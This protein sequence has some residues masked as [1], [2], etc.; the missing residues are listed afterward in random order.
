ME[1]KFLEGEDAYNDL[2]NSQAKIRD[3]FI[4]DMKGV[5]VIMPAKKQTMYQIRADHMALIDEIEQN[6]GELT[7]ELEQALSLTNEQFQQKAVSYGYVI[8]HFDDDINTIQAEIK[9]L[10][11][12]EDAY[13]RRKELFKERLSNAMIDFGFEKITTPLLTLSFRKS[14]SVEITNKDLIPE[15]YNMTKVEIN[16]NKSAIKQ[17][18][19]D[20]ATVPGAQIVVKQNLQI[21]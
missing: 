7:P 16:P 3:E 21:K 17:A 5:Q 6:E 9:R 2:L 18:I 10:S 1:Q 19:K 8:K 20:G 12:I 13:Q 11:L 15:V 14:E 4:S